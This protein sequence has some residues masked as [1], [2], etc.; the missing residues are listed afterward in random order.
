MWKS[1]HLLPFTSR[2]VKIVIDARFEINPSTRSFSLAINQFS[3]SGFRFPRFF[4]ELCETY[5]SCSRLTWEKR[6]SLKFWSVSH[7]CQ[8][9]TKSRKEILHNVSERFGILWWRRCQTSFNLFTLDYFH[10]FRFWKVLE[11]PKKFKT[12]FHLLIYQSFPVSFAR[13]W[14][15]KLYSHGLFSSDFRIF[16]AEMR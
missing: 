14:E 4:Y 9:R 1:L 6:E 15:G 10:D 7:N 2:N 5:A 13:K 11:F 16:S 12:N 3:S 8:K